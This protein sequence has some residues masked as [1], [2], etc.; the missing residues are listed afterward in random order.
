[1]LNCDSFEPTEFQAVV[2]TPGLSLATAKVLSA[3][4]S[5]PESGGVFN[6]DPIVLPNFSGAA[7]DV[8]RLV[9]Q[10]SSGE[11]RLQVGPARADIFWQ[12]KT[13]QL[14]LPEF[15]DRVAAAVLTRYLEI[16][17][18]TVDRLAVVSKKVANEDQPARSLAVHFCRDE[19]IRGP[20][21]R[22]EQFE[23]HAHKVFRL[24][25]LFDVNSWFRCKTA[26]L[27]PTSGGRGVKVI[28]DFNT[29][30]DADNEFTINQIME[31]FRVVPAGF[32]EVLK[33]YFP[34]SSHAYLT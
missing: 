26:S 29:L 14:R 24:S 20:L 28:Q 21:N 13:E 34:A 17:G 8:P 31:F 23:L 19:W 6:G 27:A 3:L 5:D 33:L 11:Y 15:L 10:S 25:G 12:R 18:A 7:V 9:L 1:M 16:T 2:Y 4:S 22:P 30:A 32:D